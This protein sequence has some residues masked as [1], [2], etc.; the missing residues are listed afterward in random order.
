[1]IPLLQG[2]SGITP[3]TS[4][5]VF[6]INQGTTEDDSQSDPHPEAGLL[7]SGREDRPDMAMGVQRERESAYGH[8]NTNC[9]T[10]L[11]RNSQDIFKISFYANISPVLP[12][13][14]MFLRS[15]TIAKRSLLLSCMIMLAML[16]KYFYHA[17]VMARSWKSTMIRVTGILLQD[18]RLPAAYFPCSNFYKDAF[19]V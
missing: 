1:M 8:D 18:G 9:M 15:A 16:I 6:S 3:E 17:K 11:K 12:R 5:N 14:I 19:K 4:R 10:A 7:T 13:Y 2:H